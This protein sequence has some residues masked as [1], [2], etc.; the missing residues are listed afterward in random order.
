M[1]PVFTKIIFCTGFCLLLLNGCKENTN[2]PVESVEDDIL[3]GGEMTTYTSG[4]S[5]FSLPAPNLTQEN[6]DKHL[7]GDAQFEQKFVEAPADVNPGLGPLFNNNSCINCHVSDGRGRPPFPGG[8]LGSMLI[9]ISMPGADEHNGPNPVPGFGAQLQD[10][11]IFGYD[12]EGTITITYT[13]ITGNYP[14]GTSYI[15]KKPTYT[16]TGSVAGNV[17]LS[18]RVAPAVFGLG[19]IEAIP[20]EA[21]IANADENDLDGDGISGKPNYVWNYKTNSFEL[22]RFGWKANVPTLLQQTAGAYNGDMGITSPFFPMENCHT[23]SLCDTTNDD[24][25]ISEQ[26]LE[27][28][29]FYIQTLAV[30]SR[31]DYDKPEVK[32]GKNLFK[33]VGCNSCHITEF[34]T[35]INS[36][37]AEVSNQKIHPYSDFLLH[38]MG[39]KLSDN[40][41][42]YDATGNEWRT[43]PLWGIGLVEIVNGHTFFLHDGRATTLEEAILWH[44]GEGKKSKDKFMRLSKSERGALISFL[45]SL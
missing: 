26:T 19:L 22:G 40:R 16:I 2:S 8:K 12:A 6:L 30:P 20:E 10:K 1:N 37:I 15:L 13:E 42:D 17:L 3:S 4:S 14:D 45:K 39:D 31:R 11:A 9:R 36:K 32:R 28:V 21:I 29:E 33:E 44:N 43:A 23:N 27:A 7:L 25:E 24:P 41:P 38:D 5:A 18:P 34:K 35:G